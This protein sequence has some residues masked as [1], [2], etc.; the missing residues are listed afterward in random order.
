MQN[1][2]GLG[3]AHCPSGQPCTR[4]RQIHST[5]PRRFLSIC[6]EPSTLD[7]ATQ[8]AHK[9]F[10]AGQGPMPEAY[11]HAHY[12]WYAYI[13]V[14]AVSLIS[15]LIFIAVTKRVDAGKAEEA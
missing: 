14:G 2:P 9:L 1:S 4:R 11:A 5:R 10:L 3:A 7:V 8:A 15:L 13:G 6:P 12:L